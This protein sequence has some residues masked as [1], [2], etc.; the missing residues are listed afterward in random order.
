MTDDGWG[1]DWMDHGW[2]MGGG[3]WAWFVVPLLLVVIVLLVAMLARGSGGRT[4]TPPSGGTGQ[5]RAREI[6]DERYARGELTDEEYRERRR[7]LEGG[8]DR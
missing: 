4:R 7:H 1:M 3:G 6:L 5:T 8:S 2:G